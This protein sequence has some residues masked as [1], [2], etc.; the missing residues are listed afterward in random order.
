M[1]EYINFGLLCIILTSLG[2]LY[3]KTNKYF[4]LLKME[5]EDF[6][7]MSQGKREKLLAGILTGNSKAYLGNLYTE[8]DINTLAEEEVNR[9]FVLYESKLSAKMVKSLG[10]SIVHMYSTAVCSIFKM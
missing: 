3:W 5:V 9:L 7:E 2:Y 8:E 1:I 6:I 4:T 10:K